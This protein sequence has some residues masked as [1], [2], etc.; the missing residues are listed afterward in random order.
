MS[1]KS[2]RIIGA[3]ARPPSH[4]GHNDDWDWKKKHNDN[5]KSRSRKS[6]SNDHDC[7]W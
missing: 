1:T 3:V 2:L 4:D 7:N 5:K 6:R